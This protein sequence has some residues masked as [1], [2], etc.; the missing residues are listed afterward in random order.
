M[1]STDYFKRKKTTI[2]GKMIG[3]LLNLPKEVNV[4]E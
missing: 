2:N 3:S 4:K 1:R